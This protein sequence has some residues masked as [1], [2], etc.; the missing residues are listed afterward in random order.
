MSAAIPLRA[1]ARSGSAADL[2]REPSTHASTNFDRVRGG[3]R[4]GLPRVNSGRQQMHARTA[5]QGGPAVLAP[6]PHSPDPR[7]RTAST[8]WGPKEQNCAIATVRACLGRRRRYRRHA[9]RPVVVS[10]SSHVDGV[11]HHSRAHPAG[12]SR[13]GVDPEIALLLPRLEMR[14]RK[15]PLACRVG[16]DPVAG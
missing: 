13:I 4:S 7:R 11:L 6:A 15:R 3:R 8:A 1:T 9:G 12:V 5:K 16:D 2:H 10:K 14:N